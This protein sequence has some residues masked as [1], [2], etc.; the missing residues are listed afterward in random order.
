M[1]KLFQMIHW[2]ANDYLLLQQ[3]LLLEHG[4]ATLVKVQTWP[5]SSLPKG[6]SNQTYYCVL[7][8]RACW[9][10]YFYQ[11]LNAKSAYLCAISSNKAV[12]INQK[13]TA[14]NLADL[15]CLSFPMFLFFTTQMIP[16]NFGECSGISWQQK[17]KNLYMLI[18]LGAF[19]L[20]F[21]LF[22]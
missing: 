1:K 20:C 12:N 14:I 2:C 16:P 19:S 7:K 9:K 22:L 15:E 5:V 13:T 21:L 18:T 3:L 10:S 17:K 6:D 4:K 11:T 8:Q